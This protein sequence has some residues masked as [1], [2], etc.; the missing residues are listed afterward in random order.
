MP[1]GPLVRLRTSSRGV[2]HETPFNEVA[3]SRLSQFSVAAMGPADQDIRS[4]R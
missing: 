4:A 1:V 2:D 3:M